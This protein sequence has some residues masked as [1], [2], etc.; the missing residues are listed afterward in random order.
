MDDA[1]L[2]LA[3]LLDCWVS[4]NPACDECAYLA[5]IED[6]FL[7]YIADLWD[8]HENGNIRKG[9]VPGGAMTVSPD[10]CDDGMWMP[11]DGVDTYTAAGDNRIRIDHGT[12][13][14]HSSSAKSIILGAMLMHER[15]HFD[16]QF[17]FDDGVVTPT[18]AAALDAAECSAATFESWILSCYAC[19]VDLDE[20][21]ATELEQ[22]QQALADFKA[23][24]GC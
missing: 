3:D 18:T 14:S 13:G 12:F 24:H 7:T 19:C 15:E 21:A 4:G 11:Q 16:D 2:S 6:L 17:A 9:S 10:L 22:R 20:A 1:L 23:A 5:G 8:L